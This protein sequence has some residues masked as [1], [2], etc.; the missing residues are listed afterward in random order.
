MLLPATKAHPARLVKRQGR[1]TIWRAENNIPIIGGTYLYMSLAPITLGED[2]YAALLP[3]ACT[4]QEIETIGE[5]PTG[6]HR[7]RPT[8][9]VLGFIA[10]VDINSRSTR[11]AGKFGVTK[12]K[13][14]NSLVR[15]R[16]RCRH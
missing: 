4:Y 8:L 12:L 7:A 10:K 3:F 6:R 5:E 1:P 13:G 2:K 16:V 9:P 11:L 15:G 14:M